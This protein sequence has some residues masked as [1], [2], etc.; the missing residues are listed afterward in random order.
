MPSRIVERI[1]GVKDKILSLLE[2][3][4]DDQSK[5]M[6]DQAGLK[7]QVDR[8]N[9]LV[10]GFSNLPDKVE[11]QNRQLDD[12]GKQLAEYD[13]RVAPINDAYSYPADI[14]TYRKTNPEV[15]LL[16]Y[17]R[18]FVQTNNVVDIGVHTGNCVD[19]LLSCGYRVFAFEPQ[20]DSFDKLSERFDG[21]QTFRAFELAVSAADASANLYKLNLDSRARDVMP[22]DPGTYSTL[23]QHPLPYGAK[24]GERLEVKL[25]CLR[26]LHDSGEIPGDVSIVK[27]DTQGGDLDVIRGMGATKYAI[28]MTT[29]WDGAYPLSGGEYGLLAPMVLHMRNRG[30]PWHIVVYRVF[31]GTHSTEPRYYCNIDQ[32]VRQSWGNALFFRDYDLFSEAQKWCAAMMAANQS[33]GL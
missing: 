31:H 5:L 32:S 26:S 29:F 27:I 7:S 21:A 4:K 25:R 20:P 16:Q 13:R 19:Q 30:Y 23:V 8:L 14:A 28:V 24:Y 17:L 33:F 10:E 12:Y 1:K 18:T 2:S 11:Q 6:V 22:D 15:M 3:I 9:H